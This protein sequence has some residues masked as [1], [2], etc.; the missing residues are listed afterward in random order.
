MI[1]TF[2]QTLL[3]ILA[4]LTRKNEKLSQSLFGGAVFML[5]F[6]PFM[7]G[8]WGIIGRN[9]TGTILGML[10]IWAVSLTAMWFW[11]AALKNWGAFF[12]FFR[13]VRKRR[14]KA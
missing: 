10:S 4:I 12:T 11:P 13:R 1:Y 6:S 7:Q 9:I 5:I 3:L 14:Q 2:T 8:S